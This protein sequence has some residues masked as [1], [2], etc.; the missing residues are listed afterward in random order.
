MFEFLQ[1]SAVD[2]LT[3]IIQPES[4]LLPVPFVE[5]ILPDTN[6]PET[7]LPTP[8]T[9]VQCLDDGEFALWPGRKEKLER[10]RLER[11]QSGS[12]SGAMDALPTMPAQVSFAVPTLSVNP[13]DEAQRLLKERL[14]LRT[15]SKMQLPSLAVLNDNEEGVANVTARSVVTTARYVAI[16]NVGTAPD[17]L[18]TGRSRATTTRV[19]S[20]LNFGDIDDMF[21]KTSADE[22]EEL[23]QL[24][25]HGTG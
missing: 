20:A 25:H 9:P 1:I 24:W 2:N 5:S 13:A 10:E 23:R 22:R 3:S 11:E 15:R 17:T 14:H 4:D 18:D 8:V 16:T 21:G 7:I 19:T 6:L 12:T